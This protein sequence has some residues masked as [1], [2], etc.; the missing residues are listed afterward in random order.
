MRVLI[1][2]VSVI[3]HEANVNLHSRTD[4]YNYLPTE[5]NHATTTIEQIALLTNP[6]QPDSQRE[7]TTV[8][9]D[10]MFTQ[11]STNTAHTWNHDTY[12][13]SHS[14]YVRVRTTTTINL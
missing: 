9:W 10:T 14:F 7:S 2:F 1:I 5:I 12:N 3:D 6:N 4:T 8:T 13:P 11:S